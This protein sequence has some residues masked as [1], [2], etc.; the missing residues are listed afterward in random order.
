[1]S[2]IN[3]YSAETYTMGLTTYISTCGCGV[4]NR[5]VAVVSYI[6]MRS[7]RNC[8]HKN[9]STVWAWHEVSLTW[10]CRFIAEQTH[11]Q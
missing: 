5:P 2:A 10:S 9:P 6:E 7:L 1:M 3:S 4:R 11:L 8:Q